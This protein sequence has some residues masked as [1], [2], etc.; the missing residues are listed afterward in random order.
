[1]ADKVSAIIITKNNEHEIGTCLESV[2]WADEIVVLDSYS[3]DRTEQICRSYGAKFYQAPFERIECR[4]PAPALRI[5][6]RSFYD[7]RRMRQ[8]PGFLPWT[9]A[10]LD[11][12]ARA[13]PSVRG[14]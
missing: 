4:I 7:T 2:K 11:Q 3:D 14:A 8:S 13:R 1:M 10:S 12:A 9:K 6:A 5:P